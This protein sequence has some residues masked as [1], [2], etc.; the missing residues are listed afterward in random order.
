LIPAFDLDNSQDPE[1]DRH[2]ADYVRSWKPK[3]FHNFPGPDSDGE[4][5]VADVAMR[6]S[7][8]PTFFPTYQHYIDG[9]VVANNPSMAALAQALDSGTGNQ[10]LGE[11][12]LLS[13]G[14]G[15][16]STFID[17]HD[18]DWGIAQWAKP[19]ISL[20]IDGVGGVADYQCAHLLG[21]RYFRLC[22]LLPVAWKLDDAV[23]IPG[24]IAAADAVDLGPV[25]AWVAG[26][27]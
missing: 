19:L 7:A 2:A 22:P 5:L 9:G 16:T 17:G 8:A 25:L 20:M 23:D 14:T 6:T 13:L 12:R 15:L 1:T 11:I 18:H 3:F 26:S 24:M 10:P 21:S 4:Q 27:F